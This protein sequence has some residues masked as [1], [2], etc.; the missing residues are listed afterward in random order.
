MDDSDPEELNGEEAEVIDNLMGNPDALRLLT[1]N[2]ILYAAVSLSQ[3]AEIEEIGSR[4]FYWGSI[5]FNISVGTQEIYVIGSGEILN[6]FDANPEHKY[7]GNRLI[8]F[9]CSIN[10]FV[11]RRQPHSNCLYFVAIV[12][13]FLKL[14]THNVETLIFEK[15]YIDDTTNSHHKYPTLV[16][17][18]KLRNCIFDICSIGSD[19]LDFLTKHNDD[20]SRDYNLTNIE[21]MNCYITQ[22]NIDVLSKNLRTNY[23]IR[24]ILHTNMPKPIGAKNSEQ[25]EIKTISDVCEDYI[26]SHEIPHKM[27]NVSFSEI[28][29]YIIRNRNGYEKCENAVLLLLLTYKFTDNILSTVPIE[30]F[31][32]LLKYVWNS[33][34]TKI[35][36]YTINL[37]FLEDD[38][39]EFL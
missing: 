35:W 3:M 2:H 28:D 36:T 25:N 37:D 16:L 14:N 39:A 4:W 10:T 30:I 18:I 23:K 34:G 26:A 12:P 29:K 20:D 11:L 13:L 8:K 24:E 6:L 7:Y 17:A 9:S 1:M 5:D 38:L 19:F 27:Y 15:L 22:S 32:K 31:T 33:R 21:F